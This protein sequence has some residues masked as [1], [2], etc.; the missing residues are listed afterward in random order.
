M[1]FLTAD[2]AVALQMVAI[3]VPAGT[4]RN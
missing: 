4:I 1:S 2:S 3:R